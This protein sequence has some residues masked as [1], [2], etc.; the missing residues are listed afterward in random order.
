MAGREEEIPLVADTNV[1]LSALLR[2]DTFHSMLIKSGY[3]RIYYPEYG[4]KE[5]EAH[6]RYILSK[7]ARA[8][9]RQSIEYALKYILESVIVV[10]DELYSSKMEEAYNLMK[11]IDEKDTTF[12]ALALQLNCPIWSNDKHFMKQNAADVLTTVE[13]AGL[14]N[15]RIGNDP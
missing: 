13:I 9:Q 14:M 5:L 11:D 15:R 4:L 8:L 7:R 1:L 6:K 12:L 3:F 2:D 10:P